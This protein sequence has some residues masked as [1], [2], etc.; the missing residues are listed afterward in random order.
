VSR[1]RA[2]ALG[3][4]LAAAVAGAFFLGRGLRGGDEAVFGFEASAPTYYAPGPPGAVTRGG[5]SGFGTRGGLEGETFL[6]G[7]VVSFQA[8]SL[9]L[10]TEAG[11]MTVRVEGERSL[12][13][14]E[15]SAAAAVRPGAAVVVLTEDGRTAAALLIVAEP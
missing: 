14:I 3:L 15:R 13:G 1:P 4:L 7:R 5:F 8:G 2:A 6:S 11:P 12:Y 10:Q 9:L